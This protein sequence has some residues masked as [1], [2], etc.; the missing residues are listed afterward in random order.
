MNLSQ[1][2]DAELD[3]STKFSPVKNKI[4]LLLSD[5]S[6][7]LLSFFIAYWMM[8]GIWSGEPEQLSS[9]SN[10]IGYARACSFMIIVLCGVSWFWSHFRH[11]TYRKPFWSELRECLQMI[12]ALAIADLALVALSKWDFSRGQWCL[13]WSLSL[14]LVPFFRWFTKLLLIKAGYWQWPSLIVGCGANAYD[15]YMAINSEKLMGFDVIGFISPDEKCN[16]SPVV[17]IPLLPDDMNLIIREYNNAKLFLA[18]DYEQSELRDNWL[19]YLTA[20]GVRNVSVI[21]TLRGV[22][23]HGTDMSHFFSHEVIML[24]VRNNLARLSSRI[25]KR[26]FDILLSS[27]LLLLLSPLLFYIGWQVSRDG[28]SPIYGH[29]RVGQGGRKFKCLKFRSMII[30]SQ[31]V[32][33][34]LLA[35]DPIARDEWERDFKLKDDPRITSIGHFIRK[36]SLDELPQLWN[37]LKGEMSL[38]GPRPVVELELAR[39]G[40]DG[41]YYLLAKPG[42]TGL[43]Q[44]SGRNDVDYATRVY[45]DG[46]YVKNWSLWYDIAIMFKTIGVVLHRDGA[47]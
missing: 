39:Y 30:D 25:L 22:P 8:A 21:P 5:T 47:Y 27:S 37:V 33:D 26:S 4:S 41:Q 45:L 7:F 19:R 44:V 11:Y 14:L 28:G 17:G 16:A 10:R 42:M 24:R 35:S 18:L 20:H 9:L 23:L 3:Y 12:L 31:D 38:V 29:E 15:A 46:W 43:W 34:K 36:T 32:L 2:C 6:A 40:D 1:S 13:L